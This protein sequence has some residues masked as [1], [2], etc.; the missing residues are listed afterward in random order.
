[1]LLALESK[2]RR[3]L[4][5][6]QRDYIIGR[7]EKAGGSPLWLRTA[8]EIAKSW[9]SATAVEGH[10]ALVSD[11]AAPIAEMVRRSRCA[12]ATMLRKLRSVGRSNLVLVWHRSVAAGGGWWR[13]VTDNRGQKMSALPKLRARP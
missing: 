10:H 5:D 13:M 11:T 3:Q 12:H 6:G 1:V 4:R 8:F 7:F 9:K 2:A